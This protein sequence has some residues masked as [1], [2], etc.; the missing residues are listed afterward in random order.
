MKI[1]IRS[2]FTT[3][4]HLL[5]NISAI[6]SASRN[7]SVNVIEFLEKNLIVWSVWTFS[8]WAIYYIPTMLLYLTGLYFEHDSYSQQCYASNE[9]T[10]SQF[11][12]PKPCIMST[13][14]DA[15]I[16]PSLISPQIMLQSVSFCSLFFTIFSKVFSMLQLRMR[17]LELSTVFDHRG[18]IH[19]CTVYY[20]PI[21]LCVDCI[22]SHE[23]L[24]PVCY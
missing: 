6:H 3:S 19:V 22:Y 8:C 16:W 24:I 14:A 9:F 23:F 7:K 18:S 21:I 1:T 5:V 20:V 15:P 12:A 17:Y 11:P 4:V 13:T 2:I 10:A